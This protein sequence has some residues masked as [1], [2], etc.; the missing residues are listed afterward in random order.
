MKLK[1]AICLAFLLQSF[2]S[3]SQNVKELY[4]D[5][6][7]G[8]IEHLDEYIPEDIMITN[9]AGQLVNLKK[10]ID[11]PTALIFVYFRCPGICSPLMDGLA[12]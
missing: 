10:Q 7:V 4:Y 8:I 11:K 12:K 3:I 5:F 2:I 6:E 1:F 9:E